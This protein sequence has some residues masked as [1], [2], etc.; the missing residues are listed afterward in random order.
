M[1]LKTI[2]VQPVRLLLLPFPAAILLGSTALVITDHI[3]RP[4]RAGIDDS[5]DAGS[6]VGFI[7]ISILVGSL[8]LFLGAP[9]LLVLDAK[10]RGKR[11]YLVTGALMAVALSF[12]LSKVLVVPKFG[13]TMG[14]MYPRVF[15][16]LG[17]PVI[18]GYWLAF[19]LRV[20]PAQ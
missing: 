20:N 1:K 19:R 9:S 18:L 7:V 12:V 8:Q 17:I 2:M 10:K 16:F 4:D 11:G 15:A 14:W 5:I 6:F 3:M 13:E